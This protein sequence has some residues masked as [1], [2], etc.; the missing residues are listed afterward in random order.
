MA[1]APARPAPRRNS[2]RSRGVGRI[3]RVGRFEA[4][5]RGSRTR[6]RPR[7]QK[8]ERRWPRASAAI[9]YRQRAILP[10]FPKEQPTAALIAAKPARDA[11]RCSNAARPKRRAVDPV[12]A[13]LD[14]RRL[15]LRHRAD[16]QA[17]GAGAFLDRSRSARRA[18]ARRRRGRAARTSGC[19]R[20]DGALA[21]L[22][23]RSSPSSPPK[24][25][26]SASIGSSD[27][28]VMIAVDPSC[29]RDR[30]DT[31]RGRPR[32]ARFRRC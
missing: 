30:S 4:E 3:E 15:A 12:A 27:M 26:A 16:Q 24:W 22:S 17:V 18:S 13:G 5:P 11:R 29:S 7:R 8:R 9:R 14:L 21:K 19:G 25:A 2:A 32:C 31:G 20:W 23:S 10:S 1:D 28:R 6:A